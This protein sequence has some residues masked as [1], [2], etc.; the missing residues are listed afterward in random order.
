MKPEPDI[1]TR[2]RE[3]AQRSTAPLDIAEIALALAAIDR[4]GVSLQR[5]RNDLAAMVDAVGTCCRLFSPATPTEDCACCLGK[6]LSGRLCYRGDSATYDDLQNANLMRV[7]DRRK[8][9]PVTLG[10][11]YIHAARG[12]GWVAEG[13]N[14]PGHFLIRVVIDGKTLILDPFHGGKIVD[15]ATIR[16]LV[17]RTTG[18][19]ATLAPGAIEA[20]SD[21]GVLM[22]LQNNIKLRL[23]QADRHAEA[24]GVIERM[25]LLAPDDNMLLRDA[26]LLN[27]GLGN[28]GA[29][30][31]LLED[32]LEKSAATPRQR[33]EIA[34]FLQR[35]KAKLN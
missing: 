21:L 6:V 30:R 35:V 31:Q 12:Q 20:V 8:G 7:M 5:Y 9:L 3:A 18:G 32:F 26:G 11:L 34:L 4:N 19:H 17:E 24:L 10:I 1:E 14:T 16:D 22:R 29:A 27:A 13:L 28:L 2:L 25:R 15:A 33:E 23:L